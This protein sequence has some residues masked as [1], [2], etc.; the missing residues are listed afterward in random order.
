MHRYLQPPGWPRGSGFSHGV[1]AMGRH[2]F[3]SGQIGWDE[4]CRLVANDFAGQAQRAL[5]NTVEILATAG[6]RPEHIA[7]MTWYVTDRSEY[8]AARRKVG[9]AYRSII[10][11]HYPAMSVVQVVALMEEGAK[12]EI[13]ST[14]V[15]PLE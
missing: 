6:A 2:V 4:Q 3:V 11:E 1:Q 5:R 10:G 7:R 13:E 12:V 8:L 14:A 15:V 9:E